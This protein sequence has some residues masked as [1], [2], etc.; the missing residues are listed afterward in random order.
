MHYGWDGS[1]IFISDH[2]GGRYLGDN[3]G[4]IYDEKTN[5]LIAHG[6]EHDVKSCFF[7]ICNTLIS[8]PELSRSVE[9]FK[10]LVFAGSMETV[11]SFNIF[12][13]RL[14]NH[15]GSDIK[16]LIDQGMPKPIE[17]LSGIAIASSIYYSEQSFSMN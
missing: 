9:D 14:M 4:L 2:N 1:K 17:Y 5:T 13:S 3:I 12:I 15:S 10:F 16:A 7:D 6:R 8:R 11:E